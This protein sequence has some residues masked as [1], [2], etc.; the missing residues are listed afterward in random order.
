[1]RVSLAVLSALVLGGCAVPARADYLFDFQFG[2]TSFANHS[3]G[4]GEIVFR[5]TTLGPTLRYV[6]GDVDGFR[7]AILEVVEDDYRGIPL[8]PQ[9]E[10]EAYAL[11]EG[12]P[13]AVNGFDVTTYGWVSGAGV[14]PV[15][16]ATLSVAVPD[17]FLGEG[18]GYDEVPV[19]LTATLTITQTPE[20]S[21]LVLLGTGVMGAA[22]VVRRRLGV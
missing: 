6:S 1:M 12:P 13:F 20:P 22:G 14:Q 8:Y 2:A 17:S 16:G 7:P 9:T 15:D 21:G 4:P 5:G 19:S 18:E 10:Y 3:Y 11:T